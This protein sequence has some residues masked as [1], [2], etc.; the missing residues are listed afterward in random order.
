MPINTFAV[1]KLDKTF[2]LDAKTTFEKIK[3]SAMK[4]DL[5]QKIEMVA[6]YENKLTLRFYYSSR[7]EN[8]TE[9]EAKRELEKV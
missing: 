2:S 3:K 4:S 1:I 9:E 8:I 5:L 6:M 7:L